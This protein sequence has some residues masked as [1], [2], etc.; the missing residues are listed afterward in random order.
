MVRFWVYGTTHASRHLALLVRGTDGP[1]R[2]G[3]HS[4]NYP[5]IVHYRFGRT[6]GPE[7]KARPGLL[8]HCAVIDG[9]VWGEW[10]CE[11]CL[12]NV[13]CRFGQTDGPVRDG[14]HDWE[15]SCTMPCRF[16]R[17]VLFGP[18]GT[19]RASCRGGS[20]G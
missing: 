1:V 20:G 7:R 9:L 14:R 16:L 4:R 11:V 2:G 3:W 13:P 5:H 6:D 17:T 18:V 19:A 8:M 12:L 15:C 10:R